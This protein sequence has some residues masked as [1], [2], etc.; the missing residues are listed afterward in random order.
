[1][2]EKPTAAQIEAQRTEMIENLKE[3]ISLNK[4]GG[5]SKEETI[6]IIKGVCIDN[7]TEQLM[8]LYKMWVDKFWDEA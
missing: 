4:N 6:A 8:P 3:Q 5:Y 2:A 1:M 7:G